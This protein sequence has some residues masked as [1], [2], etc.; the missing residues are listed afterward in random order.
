MPNVSRI[1]VSNSLLKSGS[2]SEE[3]PKGNIKFVIESKLFKQTSVFDV[4]IYERRCLN[5]TCIRKWTG[6]EKFIYRSSQKSR[7]G[8]K[9]GWKY[10]DAVNF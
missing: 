10:V 8:Y 9:I 1:F 5:G 7:A 4:S 3:L 6:E 2:I